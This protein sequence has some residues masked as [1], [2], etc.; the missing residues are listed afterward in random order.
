MIMEPA[1]TSEMSLYFYQA[2]RRHITENIMI[3]IEEDHDYNL[4]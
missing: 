4:V 3:M 1:N 2:A